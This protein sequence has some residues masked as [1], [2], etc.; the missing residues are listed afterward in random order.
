MLQAQAHAS[1]EAARETGEERRKGLTDAIS[2][3]AQYAKAEASR[4]TGRA[5]ENAGEG[6]NQE[7]G[8][9]LSRPLIGQCLQVMSIALAK[10]MGGND[11]N[12][13]MM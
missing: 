2:N 9:I 6:A 7:A 11:P 3:A 8:M 13:K 5:V 4:L 10:N 12:S 1:A